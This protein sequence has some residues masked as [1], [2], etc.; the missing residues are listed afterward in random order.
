MLW[1]FFILLKELGMTIDDF[2][3]LYV[4]KVCLNELRWK[5]GYKKGI[6]NVGAYNQEHYVKIWN[7]QEDNEFLSAK[8]E[9]LNIDSPTFKQDLSAALEAKYTEVRSKLIEQSCRGA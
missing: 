1:D 8:I 6:Y 3:K 9:E 7:G 2:Y 5:N 4:G